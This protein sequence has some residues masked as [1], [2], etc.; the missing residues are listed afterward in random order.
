MERNRGE[1][2]LIDNRRSKNVVLPTK[3][4]FDGVDK[5][6]VR[7]VYDPNTGLTDIEEQ[8]DVRRALKEARLVGVLGGDSTI[9][10]VVRALI[11]NKKD[12]NTEELPF[13]LLLGGGSTNTLFRYVLEKGEKSGSEIVDSITNRENKLPKNSTLRHVS[14]RP[15]E[16]NTKNKNISPLA[17][18]LLGLGGMIPNLVAQ[19]GEEI[20]RKNYSIGPQALNQKYKEAL[21]NLVLGL[22]KNPDISI[23]FPRFIEYEVCGQKQY[24]EGIKY[25]ALGVIGIPMIANYSLPL[26]IDPN[27]ILVFTSSFNSSSELRMKLALI[28]LLL[29]I[30]HVGIRL[31]LGSNLINTTEVD[32]VRALPDKGNSI[33][34]DGDSFEGQERELRVK[35]SPHSFNLFAL[36]K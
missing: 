9:R 3:D 12:N 35:K 13:I 2:V 20:I 5:K 26:E 22:M 17:A 28:S 21:Q 25:L 18:Y 24:F 31:I 15:L 4:W 29:L 11:D 34:I 6:V 23:P 27:K 14:Y 16:I 7:S 10:T 32:R 19:A 33:C 8:S 30:P 1:I 36:E